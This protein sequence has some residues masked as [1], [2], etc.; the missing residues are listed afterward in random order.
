MASINTLVQ[1]AVGLVKA[2]GVK[3]SKLP[4]GVRLGLTGLAILLEVAES[5][6]PQPVWAHTIESVGLVILAAIG[7]VQIGRA[8]V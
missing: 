6:L 3:L 8:H 7:I 5:S 4:K 1:G 2:A